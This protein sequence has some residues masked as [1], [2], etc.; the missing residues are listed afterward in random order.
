MVNWF[1]F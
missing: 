1:T